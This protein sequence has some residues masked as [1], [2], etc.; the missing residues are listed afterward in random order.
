M[1][2][3]PTLDEIRAARRVLDD[4]VA[5]T[6]VFSW[7]A[8]AVANLVGTETSLFLKLELFQVG[9]SFKTRGATLAIRGLSPEQLRRG[10]VTASGGNHAIA[11][12]V[13]SRAAGTT[14]RVFMGR[15]ANPF[16]QQRCRDLGADVTL[17]DDVHQAFAAARAA[18]EN[19]GLAYIHPFE[20][21]PI[22]AGTA[23]VGL[24]LM[25]QVADLDAVVVPVGGG[26]LL[27]GIAAAVKQL[28]PQCAVYG[29]EPVGADTMYRSFQAGTPQ[30]IAK[31]DTIA[32][33]LG[34]PTALPY[35]FGLC[36]K[37]ADEI[38]LVTDDQL[39][40]G[41]KLLFEEMKLVAEPAA[42][43][44]TVAILGPLRERLRGKR[45]GVIVCGSNI[46]LDTF[47]RHIKAAPAALPH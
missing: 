7:R 39:R 28:R 3:F 9:G 12:A 19:D 13:A 11:V 1:L 5:T 35:S 45:V 6:P 37:F 29:V 30:E 25:E 8:A 16:R 46:D 36:R 20:G 38:V 33:S 4:V 21:K 17:V 22:A 2:D 23:T 43:A 10:V 41:M 40:W 18:S 42:A 44:A 24:E 31:I 47:V 15:Q 14:A 32:D 34:S 27:A 26:G